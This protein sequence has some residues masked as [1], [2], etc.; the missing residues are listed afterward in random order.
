MNIFVVAL[1]SS[2]RYTGRRISVV[3]ITVLFAVILIVPLFI[4]FTSDPHEVIGT[5]I[6]F[7]QIRFT[8]KCISF[9][10]EKES[11]SPEIGSISYFLFAPT[12]IYRDS[13]PR[14]KR[15]DWINIV[16]WSMAIFFMM[17]FTLIILNGRNGFL[18]TFSRVGTKKL[19]A[20][21]YFELVQ[22]SSLL[23]LMNHLAVGYAFLHCWLNIWSEILMFGDRMFYKNWLVTEGMFEM[24]TLWNYVV[25]SWIKRYV[26]KP[27]IRRCNSPYVATLVSFLIS[28][29]VHDYIIAVS[30]KILF[31]PF[32]FIVL[33]A[34]LFAVIPFTL[35]RITR[36]QI[37]HRPDVEASRETAPKSFNIHF[38]CF[39]TLGNILIV[40]ITALRYYE[41]FNCQNSPTSH[42]KI[43][44]PLTAHSIEC[45]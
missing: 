25:H 14:A 45:S 40:S 16:H 2:L 18:E 30:L 1:L 9:V 8:M 29:F 20:V 27:I 5:A 28:F 22:Q 4:R 42:Q 37:M 23:A 15:R 39:L 33:N 32:T 3:L 41:S 17:W 38:F 19:T 10:S 24:F 26:Y 12:L 13:Y 35:E 31:F 11:F 6:T 21:D 36:L 34:A 44:S 43:M 7:E